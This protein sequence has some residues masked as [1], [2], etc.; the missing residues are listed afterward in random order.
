MLA[1]AHISSLGY[2]WLITNNHLTDNWQKALNLT[3]NWHIAKTVTDN[4]H[5]DSP[6]PLPP[7]QTLF[8][9]YVCRP[10][11]EFL[12]TTYEKHKNLPDFSFSSCL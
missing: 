9:R 11:F 10:D 3:D 7:I 4:W 8:T 2:L 6:P 5:L 12:K 1:D